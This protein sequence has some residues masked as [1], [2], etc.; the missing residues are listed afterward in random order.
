MG[1]TLSKGIMI[2]VGL[3]VTGVLVLFLMATLGVIKPHINEMALATENV[4]D[5]KAQERFDE[6]D[7]QWVSGTKVLRALKEWE[8]EPFAIVY[9]THRTV[10]NGNYGL[11][12]NGILTGGSM[13]AYG[14]LVTNVSSWRVESSPNETFLTKDFMKDANGNVVIDPG[15][16]RITRRDTSIWWEAIDQNGRFYSELIKDKTGNVIGICFSQD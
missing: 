10:S 12:F 2:S 11:N 4:I 3:I 13:S 15:S 5:A 9:I 7:Q 16:S 1:T 14:Y 8:G 6:F